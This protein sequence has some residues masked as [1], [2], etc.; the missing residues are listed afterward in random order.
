MERAA[1]GGWRRWP[2]ASSP[3]R[4]RSDIHRGKCCAISGSE[5]K[6]ETDMVF[7]PVNPRGPRNVQIDARVNV[8]AVLLL[9]G[10]IVPSI[11]MGAVTNNPLFLLGILLGAI[12][13]LSPK[14]AK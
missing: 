9:L 10:F 12:L 7:V 11:I 14:V 8:I 6:K 4:R 2:T 5:S 1:S 3:R 13:S